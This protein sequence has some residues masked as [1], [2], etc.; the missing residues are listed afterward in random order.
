MDV[1]ISQEIREASNGHVALGTLLA[2]VC[3]TEHN[4]HLWERVENVMATLRDAYTLEKVSTIPQIS[5]LRETYRA[6][7]T[8]PQK[9]RGANEALLRRILKGQDLYRIN[10]IVDTNNLVSLSSLRA[11][12][13]YDVS[14]IGNTLMFQVGQEGQSYRAIGRN[15]LNIARLPVLADTEGPFG[16]PTADSERAKITSSCQRVLM[17]IMAFDGGGIGLETQLNQLE[18]LMLKYSDA[19]NISVEIVR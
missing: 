11:V 13:T 5:A 8:K 6:L 2:D 9:Y 12:A 15:Q 14:K 17:V 4:P 10:T 16:S 7:G 3:V 1:G 19:S 18:E